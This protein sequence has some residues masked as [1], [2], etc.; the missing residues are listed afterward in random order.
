MQKLLAY[1]LVLPLAL[2]AAHMQ[3][4]DNSSDFL[5]GY[6]TLFFSMGASL[7]GRFFTL[8]YMPY[9]YVFEVETAIQPNSIR[10]AVY[11]AGTHPNIITP[12]MP[13]PGLSDSNISGYVTAIRTLRREKFKFIGALFELDAGLNVKTWTYTSGQAI[14][15]TI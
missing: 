14:R 3:A 2:P 9:R 15:D 10:S 12:T 7:Q 13:Q 4:Q 1:I 8:G 11:S 6:K 5:Y